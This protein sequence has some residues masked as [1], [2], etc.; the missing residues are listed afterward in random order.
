MGDFHNKLLKDKAIAIACPK[1]DET[2][3]YVQKLADI[4][5]TGKPK[6]MTVVHMEVPCCTGLVRM[7]HKAIELAG[8]DLQLQDSTISLRGQIIK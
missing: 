7:A 3:G 5:M 1:L 8:S 6:S 4:L 2:G